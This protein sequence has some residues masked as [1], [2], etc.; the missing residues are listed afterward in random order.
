MSCKNLYIACFLAGLL[1]LGGC[2]ST[3]QADALRAQVPTDLVSSKIIEQVPFFPQQQFYCGPTTLS[4]IFN[5]YGDPVVAEEIAPKL[6]IPDKEGSLQ[7]EMISATRQYGYLPYSEHSSL[8][9]ILYLLEEDIP[10]IVF[11]NLSISILPQWH[12]AVATGY[13]LERHE[14]ILHTGVTANHRMSFE[15]F[16]RTWARANYWMLVPLPVG[17]T[18]GHLQPFKYV[19]AAYDMLS[20]GKQNAAVENLI[21]ATKQWPDEWLAYFLIANHFIESNPEKSIHWF[22]AGLKNGQ[23]QSAY[24]NNY[25]HVLAQVG[26]KDKALEVLQDARQRFPNDTALLNTYEQVRSQATALNCL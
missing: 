26:C 21:A 19:S 22:E 2:Q 20:V 18:S 23:Y 14:L 5:F 16:E 6:F 8:E 25:A 10:V 17:K 24:T 1:I 3:P 11:Q 13:D 4:E 15:L 7:L 9:T 12:Y